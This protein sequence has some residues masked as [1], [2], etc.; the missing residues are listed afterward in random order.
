MW[1]SPAA[2]EN[3]FP[4]K[5]KIGEICSEHSLLLFYASHHFHLFNFS[6]KN[7]NTLFPSHSLKVS[8]ISFFFRSVEGSELRSFILCAFVHRLPKEYLLYLVRYAYALFIF[9]TFHFICGFGF[10]DSALMHCYEIVVFYSVRCF[11]L[12]LQ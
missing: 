6:F 10:E 11:D 3:F 2:R 5:T 4:V 12:P 7:I 1:I 8:S 9:L